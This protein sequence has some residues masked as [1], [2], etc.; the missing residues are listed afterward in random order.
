MAYA[1]VLYNRLVRIG[2]EMGMSLVRNWAATPASRGRLGVGPSYQEKERDCH[3]AFAM[4]VKRE[5]DSPPY[6]ETGV[7]VITHIL[8]KTSETL[9]DTGPGYF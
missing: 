6:T 2:F 5:Q 7:V 8:K 4:I 9:S 3:T 1:S